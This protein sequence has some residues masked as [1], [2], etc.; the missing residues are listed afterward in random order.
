MET[1][2][3][4]YLKLMFGKHRTLD[5]MKRAAEIKYEHMPNALYKFRCFSDHALSALLDDCLF[6]AG[7]DYLNDIREA[8]ITFLADKL[9]Q[10]ALQ[11]IYDEEREKD[12]SLPVATIKN[13]YD[14]AAVFHVIH[15]KCHA[16]S[17]LPY[18]QPG[19]DVF[20]DALISWAKAKC[21]EVQ[22]QHLHSIRNLYNVCCFSSV[23]EEDLMWSHYADGHKGFCIQYDFKALGPLDD[24]VQLLLPVVYQDSPSVEIGDLEELDGSLVMYALSLKSIK[25]SYEKEWR[26]FFMHTER[27]HPE[28]MPK[29]KAIY[30]G[31]NVELDNKQKM[32]EICKEKTIPLYQLTLPNVRDSFQAIQI[33]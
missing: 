15:M 11:K 20:I 14:L 5:T 24:R 3:S 30:L 12:S 27:P 9:K 13:E 22:D 8:P 19:A 4:D 17:T 32:C 26:S 2:H 31:A 7:P 16:E 25:W 23:L 1:W 6:S 10:R 18:P 28:L 21:K 29:P 33:L